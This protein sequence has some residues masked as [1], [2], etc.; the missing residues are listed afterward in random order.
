MSQVS[1]VAPAVSAPLPT[2][3]RLRGH[4]QQDIFLA[5][6]NDGVNVSLVTLRDGR[7]AV[8]KAEGVVGYWDGDVAGVRAAVAAFG[9]LTRVVPPAP[10][11]A[12]QTAPTPAPASEQRTLEAC[13][14]T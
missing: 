1:R 10:K 5:S 6:G 12:S 4:I 8:I 13:T 7:C 3:T 11:R 9:A 14:S 2:A